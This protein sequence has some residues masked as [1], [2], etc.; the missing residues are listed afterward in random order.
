MAGPSGSHPGR[1]GGERSSRA[2][3]ERERALGGGT[4]RG[5]GMSPSLLDNKYP[6][7]K[8]KRTKQYEASLENLAKVGT[9]MGGLVGGPVGSMIAGGYSAADAIA[10]GTN[11][12][13]GALDPFSGPMGDVPSVGA[14][15]AQG[16]D[17]TNR[18][19]D[20]ATQN[21][22]NKAKIKNKK[23]PLSKGFKLLA[24][25]GGTLLGS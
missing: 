11:P 9:I 25:A 1:T 23:Q 8:G 17:S 3:N 19:M 10:N 4:G 20:P 24:G 7:A 13:S 15:Y 5:G 2:Q 6:G 21:A 18:M 12:I 14:G 16:S 22:A